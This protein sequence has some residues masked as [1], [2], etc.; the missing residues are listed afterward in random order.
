M[1]RSAYAVGYQDCGCS[2]S[3]SVAIV[4]VDSGKR[5]SIGSSDIVEDHMSLVHGLAVTT[6][7]IELSECLNCETVDTQG[8]ASI[9][10]KEN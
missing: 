3:G 2:Y 7:A 6:R 4:A 8:T 10:L 5:L 1:T 9:V